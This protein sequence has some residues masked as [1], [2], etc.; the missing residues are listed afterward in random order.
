MKRAVSVRPAENRKLPTCS[1]ITSPTNIVV[2]PA[3]W[4]PTSISLKPSCR[5][6]RSVIDSSKKPVEPTAE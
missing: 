5:A 4:W 2:V 6:D 3:C 1:S